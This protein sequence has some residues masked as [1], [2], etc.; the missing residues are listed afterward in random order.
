MMLKKRQYVLLIPVIIMIYGCV[1]IPIPEH[2]KSIIPDEVMRFLVPG[3]TTRAD[4]LLR[5][6]D[7]LQRLEEDRYFL[8]HWKTIEGYWVFGYGYSG[9]AS[10][11][12][13]LHYLCLEFTPE[14]LLK[15]W[16]HF[17]GGFLWNHPEKQILEWMKEGNARQKQNPVP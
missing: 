2:G 17:E 11:S 8:Y 7:P 15:R 1:Y 14:N 10:P 13:D 3:K 12:K 9:A 6:G 16:K 5:F 4:V